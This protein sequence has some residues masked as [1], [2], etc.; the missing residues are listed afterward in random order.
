MS[1]RTTIKGALE[2]GLLASGVAGLARRRRRA[3]LLVLAYHDIVPR[4]E[5]VRGDG[6]LHLPQDSFAVQL[7]RLMETHDVVELDRALEVAGRGGRPRAVITFDDAYRGALTAGVD[8]LVARGLP[9]TVF[10]CPGLLGRESFWWD[11]LA[12]PDTGVL[13][14]DVR[15]RA[16]ERHAGKDSAI[17]ASADGLPGHDVGTAAAPGTEAELTAA[18]GRPGITVGSHTWSHPN[19]ARLGAAELE[20]ELRRPLEWLEARYPRVSAWLS[21]PYG[22]SS[23][24]VGAAARSAGYRGGLLVSG[25]WVV[26]SV[27]DRFTVP[28]VNIP[29]GLTPAGFQLRA[30][31]LFCA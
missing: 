6:S 31:G 10:A 7:D 24:D 1:V 3:D 11:A 26:G 9:A 8:E 4:G 25:G 5:R 17:R 13:D 30:A 20:G 23:P 14:P 28:R 19:L 16:L 27:A 22:L 12:D 15:E 21:Y 29:A 18:A 2:W